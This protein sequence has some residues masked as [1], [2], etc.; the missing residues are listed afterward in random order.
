[1]STSKQTIYWLNLLFASVT[2]VAWVGISRYYFVRLD[3]T[4]EKRY[5]LRNKSKE[6]LAE[7]RKPMTIEVYIEGD[8]PA[9]MQR[10]RN[11]LKEMLAELRLYSNDQLDFRFK[12]PLAGK[13]QDE[14]SKVTYQLA[15]KG[16]NPINLYVSVDGKQVEKLIFPGGVIRYNNKELGLVFL[17][18]A[19]VSSS[20]EVINS[21]IENL[22]YVIVSGIQRVLQSRKKTIWISQGH[23]ERENLELDDLYKSLSASY[24]V[25]RVSL[26]QAP[27]TPDYCDI[28]LI[29]GPTKP[30]S[31]EEK[32]QLDQYVVKG[33]T[34]LAFVDG[35]R[36]DEDSLL[37]NRSIAGPQNHQLD[38]LLFRWGARV[39]PDIIQDLQCSVIP[40]ISGSASTRPQLLPW[41]Y[42][43]ILTRYSELPMVKNM[44]AVRSTYVSSIDTVKAVGIRKQPLLYTSDYVKILQTPIPIYLESAKKP[45]D[46]ELYKYHPIPVGYLLEGRFKSMYTHRITDQKKKEIDFK[47]TL[48]EG[49]VILMSDGDFVTNKV[50]P[51]RSM[52][53]PM[54]FDQ[55]AGKKFANK[56][57]VLS[58]VEYLSGNEELVNIKQKEFKIR[59]LDKQKVKQEKQYWQMFN[60]LFPLAVLFG[61]GLLKYVHRKSQYNS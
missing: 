50:S 39:N 11:S 46:P 35:V 14:I 49:K 61:F 41:V 47:E 28:F 15:S 59:P 7:I 18:N 29:A 22:E 51:D 52:V 57:L 10:L 20:S 60:I 34:V 43:P 23:G 2:F 38:D 4:E 13:S 56:D 1:M 48:V 19:L 53:Y 32:L 8:L 12:D 45:L 25:R 33:G 9:G 27:L 54:G 30:W 16:I 40:V 31:D 58:F 42:V 36:V 24:D 55:Y 5:T 17:N 26:D 37:V 21:S 44:G 6:I 3:L